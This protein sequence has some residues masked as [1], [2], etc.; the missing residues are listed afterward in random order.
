MNTSVKDQIIFDA[1]T[2]TLKWLDDVVIGLNLCPFAAKPRRQKQIHLDIYP[3]NENELISHLVNAL[4][5]LDTISASERE[6]TLIVLTQCL[7]SFDDYNQ[8][9]ADTDWVIKRG[10]W[11]GIYQVASFHPD[12]QFAGSHSRAAENLTN[13]SPFPILHLL[14][15]A[16]L[17]QV[18]EKYPNP[19]HIPEDNIKRVES[20]S[21]QE[22]Q[23]LFPYLLTT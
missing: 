2:K 20:L 18:L 19:E 14:R 4:K 5:E 3:G 1:K 6:T 17:E 9:L 23:R 8:F 15:E 10:G 16:S 21:E 11:S 22:K 7:Q 12:Y 13:R